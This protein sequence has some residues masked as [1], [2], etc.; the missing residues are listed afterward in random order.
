MTPLR[1]AILGSTRG[2]NLVPIVAAIKDKTLN[3]EIGIVISN[4]TIRREFR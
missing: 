3:A 2:S 1:I 4:K